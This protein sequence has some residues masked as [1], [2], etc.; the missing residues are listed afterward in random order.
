MV[1]RNRW[2][3]WVNALVDRIADS[4][5]SVIGRLAAR[6]LGAPAPAGSV[7]TSTFAAR[8]IRV[9]IA[10]VNYAAQGTAWARALESGRAN[11]SARNMAIDV[12]GGFSFDADLTVPVGTYHNDGD[13]QVRQF[14]AAA[15]STHVLI[16]AEEPPFGRLLGRSV[17]RQA[18][19]LQDRGVDIAY[20]A[21]GTDARLPSAHAE[22]SEWSYY[23][24]PTVYLP[25]AETLARRNIDLLTR[26][27]RPLFVSTPDLLL[28]LPTA[29]WCPVV[30]DPVRWS[31]ARTER[32]SG[33]PLRVV[34][35]PSNPV[36]KGTP[37]I[38]PTLE[39]LQQDG[40]ID[41]RLIQGIPSSDMPELFAG[42]DVLLDQFRLGSY[43]VAACEAM[44]AGCIVVGQISEQVRDAVSERTGLSLPILEAD[45]RSLERVLRELSALPDL[46]PLRR[47]S[48]EF[49]RD[50]HDGRRSADALLTRWITPA[51]SAS[52]E[53]ADRAP[54]I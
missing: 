22:R 33:A 44:A 39:R 24:D 20:M 45:P 4:P 13:W 42:A 40:V 10:P 53:D 47:A 8:P 23:R 29:T 52:R 25:R 35:A 51:T 2:P 49:V 5:M 7:A 17:E 6:R 9:L 34:H 15:R 38:M 32:R 11:L 37:L 31:P 3:S 26:S 21:H 36:L 12:P 19:A 46:T 41:F 18:A 43:G 30:V 54:S 27:G 1:N 28:D 50:V 16:E 48:A 14:E